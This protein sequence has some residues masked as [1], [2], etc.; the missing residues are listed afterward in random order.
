MNKYPGVDINCKMIYIAVVWGPK[1]ISGVKKTLVEGYAEYVSFG[2]EPD[3]P[4]QADM[5]VDEAIPLFFDHIQPL[6]NLGYK[7]ISPCPT[8]SQAGQAWIKSFVEQ[9]RSRGGTIDKICIHVYTSDVNNFISSV[10]TIMGYFP[11]DKIWI[12]EMAAMNFSGSGPQLD[13]A[14]VMN[15]LRTVFDWMK[16]Q[17]AIEM[18]SWFGA[19]TPNE[20]VKTGVTAANSIMDD[21]GLPNELGRL[22]L[23][24]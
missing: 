16:G 10:E 23:S 15:F 13:S 1:D 4:G 5:T 18:K 2:N 24:Y 20:I 8:N 11:Q 3:Q 7:V 17:N 6:K 9:V 21:N 12:M 14:G 22:Y 19:F